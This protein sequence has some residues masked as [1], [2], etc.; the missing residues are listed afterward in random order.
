MVITPLTAKSHIDRARA[1]LRARGRVQLVGLAYA[2]G[3]VGS[4]P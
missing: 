4:G 3:L 1:K 2:S